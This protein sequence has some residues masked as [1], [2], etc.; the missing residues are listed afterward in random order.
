MK[1]IELLPIELT[2][3]CLCAQCNT[4]YVEV[5]NI[6][7]LLC[8]VH[9]GV[10]LLNTRG[11]SYF[12]CC[13]RLNTRE[14]CTRMDHTTEKFTNQ[15]IEERFNQIQAFSIMILPSLLLPYLYGP[16]TKDVVLF[17]LP[18][19]FS[20]SNNTSDKLTF[21]LP[22]LDEAM[23]RFHSK[24]VYD[25]IS[26]IDQMPLEG[27][28]NL[29]ELYKGHYDELKWIRNT[30]FWKSQILD[31]LFEM[32]Q[33][34]ELFEKELSAHDGKKMRCEKECDL[35]WK[36]INNS[37]SGDKNKSNIIINFMIISRLDRVIEG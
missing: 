10:K 35:I 32:S 16:P 15:S 17:Q 34:S 25:K 33:H 20:H 13:N 29:F 26:V 5:D 22:V 30:V 31:S 2:S 28:P 11:Q 7:R 9:P 14:G 36:N 21:N 4:Q 1:N 27:E 23:K 18:K 6:G 19:N 12:S 8:F 37:K 3:W 24:L